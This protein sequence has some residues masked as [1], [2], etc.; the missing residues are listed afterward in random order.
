MNLTNQDKNIDPINFFAIDI[1]EDIGIESPSQLII[2]QTE[3][4]LRK[5]LSQLI[6]CD[7]LKVAM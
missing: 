5:N 4:N 7:E 1:L 6:A 2:D 3:A